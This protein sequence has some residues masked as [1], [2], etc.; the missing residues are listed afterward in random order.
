M[1]EPALTQETCD[2]VI[3]EYNDFVAINGRFLGRKNEN[4]LSQQELAE[5]FTSSRVFTKLRTH[6]DGKERVMRPWILSNVYPPSMLPLRTL[7]PIMLSEIHIQASN[8]G[9]VVVLRTFTKPSFDRYLCAGVEDP[10]GNIDLVVL[11]NSDPF[12]KSTSILPN[13]LVF[14]VKEPHYVVFSNGKHGIVIEHPSDMVELDLANSLVPFRWKQALISLYSS[15]PSVL[16]EKANAALAGGD[17]AGASRIYTIGLSMCRSDDVDLRDH[18]RRNRAEANL[19]LGRYHQAWN[20]AL[21]SLSSKGITPFDRKALYRAGRAS[22]ELGQFDKARGY[23]S[24]AQALNPSDSSGEVMRELKRALARLDEAKTGDYDFIAI[25]ESVK[26]G[27][28]RVDAASFVLNTEVKDFGGTRRSGLI[29]T[30]NIKMGE[31]V[32][33][34]KAFCASFEHDTPAAAHT[35][36]VASFSTPKRRVFSDAHARLSSMTFQKI[37]HNPCIASPTLN[38]C[39]EPFA[40]SNRGG[41]VIDGQTLASSFLVQ[42][43]LEINSFALP[44][45]RTSDLQMSLLKQSSAVVTNDFDPRASENRSSGLFTHASLINHACIANDVRSFVGDLMVIRA[46]KDIKKGDEITLAYRNRG[47]D[48]VAFHAG[49]EQDY[50]FTCQCPIC[51]AD[52]KCPS[53]SLAKRAKLAASVQTFYELK[54]QQMTLPAARRPLMADFYMKASDLRARLEDTYNPSLYGELPRLALWDLNMFCLMNYADER[55]DD[56]PAILLNMALQSLRD[57]GLAITVDIKNESVNI[58]SST[59][60]ESYYDVDA[61]IC[62]SMAY[63]KLHKYVLYEEFRKFAGVLWKVKTG[64]MVGFSS[65]YRGM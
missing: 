18:L 32:M 9:R 31:L 33:C 12:L 23:F 39:A 34:E 42:R 26:V 3:Q 16:K 40:L 27:K 25:S 60:M 28:A 65:M 52:S 24:K 15:D 51:K 44:P 37:L 22:Y 14:A 13:G 7:K 48:E 11:F 56:D 50:G 6:R 19:S 53:S 59:Y 4:R 30:T 61:A 8:Y 58:D 46:A 35:D 29:A 2:L 20:D 62:A 43:V 41:E 17:S 49:L 64:S 21:T 36:V 10:D 1:A 54:T 45:L 63:K 5:Q 47:A 38:L 57:F 55:S